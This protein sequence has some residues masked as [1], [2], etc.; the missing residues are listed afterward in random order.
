MYSRVALWAPWRTWIPLLP[1]YHHHQGRWPP[2]E[3]GAEKGQDLTK[4]LTGA[5][6]GL[7]WE[8]R[9]GPEWQLEV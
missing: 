6:W 9:M 3:L 2:G 4:V 8:G 1:T 5:L 7:L